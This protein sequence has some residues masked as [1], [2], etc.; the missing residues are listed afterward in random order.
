MKSV[1][2]KL[3]LGFSLS[4]NMILIFTCILNFNLTK[5]K[6]KAQLQANEIAVAEQI[7]NDID[8]NMKEIQSI[9]ASI[10]LMNENFKYDREH[11]IELKQYLKQSLSKILES[12][13]DLETV[14]TFFK[15]DMK[16]ENELPYECILRDENMKASPFEPS[17]INDFKYWEQDWYKVAQSYDKYIWTEPYYEEATG[18]KLISGVKKMIDDNGTFIGVS[19][20]DVN[21]NRIENIMNNL[22]LKDGSFCFIVS[23]QG[24]YIYH[25]NKEYILRKNISDNNDPLSVLTDKLNKDIEGFSDIIIEDKKYYVFSQ[26]IDSTG[27]NLVVAYPVDII[28]NELYDLLF[29]DIIGLFIGSILT[30]LTS[31]LISKNILKNINKGVAL[32]NAVSKGDLTYN[33]N[34]ETKD[35]IG[36]LINSMNESSKS[37]R[38]I[39]KS[40]NEDI[41]QLN[42]IVKELQNSGK[43]I[44][45]ASNDI[46]TQ[47]KTVQTDIAHQDKNINEIYK[48]FNQ[49]DTFMDNIYDLSEENLKK[50]IQSVKVI[51]S[52]KNITETSI[53]ELTNVLNLI[54]FAVNSMNKLEERTKQIEETLDLVKNISK[55]TKLLSLNASIEASRAGESGKGFVIVAKEIKKFSQETEIV[56]QKT[57]NLIKEIIRESNS[58]AKL[59]NMDINDSIKELNNIKNSQSALN[60][61]AENL[62]NFEEFAK[63]LSNLVELQK[64]TS[65]VVKKSLK[66]ISLSS[67]KIENSINDIV[68]YNMKQEKTVH[69]LNQ[70]SKLLNIITDSLKTLISRFKI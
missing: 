63:N 56:L 2:K 12:N 38:D 17:D 13:D 33:V 3:I 34:L 6:L 5:N 49:I 66:D 46:T 36:I 22:D 9:G 37:V 24:N 47:I 58:T 59:M 4:M 61:I 60:N 35:E 53:K 27:W 45:T 30:I 21:M 7:S 23:D 41:T 26:N 1:K 15:P 51:D 67:N 16:I 54:K 25:P 55:Q 69:I 20:I 19:G 65:T 52:T 11:Y 40:I 14:Y 39:V 50:T 31:I 42:G 62:N 28:T 32:S 48:N 43:N 18:R 29:S 10:S 64:N 8:K 70:N 44:S 68:N 57:E